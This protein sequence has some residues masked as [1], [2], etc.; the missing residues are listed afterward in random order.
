MVDEFAFTRCQRC[1]QT[2]RGPSQPGIAR[3]FPQQR[4]LD[5]DVIH[6]PENLLQLAQALEIGPHSF[7]LLV[8]RRKALAAIAQALHLDAHPVALRRIAPIG[9]LRI[10]AQAVLKAPQGP[11]SEHGDRRPGIGA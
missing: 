8:R 5:G 9:L 10:L 1:P 2:R 6:L 3:E 11:A 7:V 4:A